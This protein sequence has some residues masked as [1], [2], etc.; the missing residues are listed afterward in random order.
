MTNMHRD[1]RNER[2]LGTKTSLENALLA[3]VKHLGN[4][5]LAMAWA[6]SVWDPIDLA[7]DYAEDTTRE[8]DVTVSQE[9]KVIKR[10]ESI[11][12]RL[13][14]A[15]AISAEGALFVRG[16]VRTSPFSSCQRRNSCAAYRVLSGPSLRTNRGFD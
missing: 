1:E 4:T 14:R 2:L 8:E 9:V 6:Y 15:G 11:K 3:I 13:G 16:I 5:S 7:R 10:L 12:A